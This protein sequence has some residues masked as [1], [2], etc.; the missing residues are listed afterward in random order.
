MTIALAFPVF[1]A[2]RQAVVPHPGSARRNPLGELATLDRVK[3]VMEAAAIT[4]RTLRRG[5]IPFA[6]RDVLIYLAVTC[7]NRSR[8]AAGASCGR[9]RD[10]A[11]KACRA[12]E[13]ARETNPK[14]EALLVRL[15][16]ELA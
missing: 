3:A 15:E 5:G 16:R 12:I 1:R 14:L 11:A 9:D 10:S 6:A 4:N 13:D 2:V 8:T 7:G